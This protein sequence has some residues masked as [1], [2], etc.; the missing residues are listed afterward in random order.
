[1]NEQE[2]HR[3]KMLNNDY[4]G[5]A[6]RFKDSVSQHDHKFIEQ[7]VQNYVLKDKDGETL[8]FDSQ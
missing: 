2:I 5:Y 8:G 3:Q 7:W 1:M 4:Q 6:S